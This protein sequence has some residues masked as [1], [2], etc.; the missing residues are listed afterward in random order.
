[1]NTGSALAS[2]QRFYA[3]ETAYLAA[4]DPDF[5]VIAST[6]DPDC[7]IYQPASLPYGGEWRGHEGF[8]AWMKAFAGEWATLEVRDAQFF[9]SG[10]V[11]ISKSQVYARTRVSGLAVNWPLLQFFKIRSGKILELRPFYWDTAA[12]LPFLTS[13]KDHAADRTRGID[14]AR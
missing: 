3:A 4:D 6:L 14:P 12:L 7:V 11:V 13:E 1:M 9:E 5:G 8:E 10:N 2:L